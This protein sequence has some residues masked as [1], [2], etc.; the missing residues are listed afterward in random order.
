MAVGTL[1]TALQ[2]YGCGR[3]TRCARWRPDL[4][5]RLQIFGT[6]RWGGY[7][8]LV[9]VPARVVLPLQAG[10]DPLA[11][12]GG[13]CIVSTAWHMVNRLAVIRPGD[14]VLVPSASGGVAGSLVQCAKQVGATV[15]ATTGAAGKAGYVESLGADV[16]VVR[17]DDTDEHATD[18]LKA[19]GGRPFDAVLDTMGGKELFGTHLSLLRDDG[20]L[21]TC[22]AHAGEVVVLDVVRLFQ[23]G[24]R[25]VGFRMAPPDE[26]AR[27]AGADPQRAGEGTDRGHLPDERCRGATPLRPVTVQGRVD[28]LLA[29]D[30]QPQRLPDADVAERRLVHA[31]GEGDDGPGA[32]DYGQHSAGAG[33]R[34]DLRPVE[35]PGAVDDTGGQGVLKGDSVAEVDD[36]QRVDMRKGVLPVVRIAREHAPL[37]RAEAVVDEWP[38]SVRP[39]RIEA[40]RRD[41]Q[42]V[43]ER[44][45]LLDEPGEWFAHRD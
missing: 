29:V 24:W 34:L 44:R 40:R 9:S 1:V 16:V 25:I 21:V 41:V 36:R 42:V 28:Q 15:V 19:T 4:C 2:Q 8:E 20:I 22:G 12:A 37:A 5:E 26:L 3:C 45:Q 14:L 11:V 30:K 39:G 10:D 32:R 23:H 43:P 33:Q 31:H 17:A 7:G 27:G 6:T 18:L 35:G 38:G 13:Q